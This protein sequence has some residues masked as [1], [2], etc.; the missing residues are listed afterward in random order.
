MYSQYQITLDNINK[1]KDI[2]NEKKIEFERFTSDKKL[3]S[4]KIENLK[5]K[6]IELKKNEKK[7]KDINKIIQNLETLSEIF[8]SFCQ[9]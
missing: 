7:I 1:K 9:Y 4:E 2:I 8:I 5:H 3:I 6:I